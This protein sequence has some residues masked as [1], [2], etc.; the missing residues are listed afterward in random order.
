MREVPIET[1]LKIPVHSLEQVRTALGRAGA[2]RAHGAIREDNYLLDD[3]AGRMRT[4][5]RVLRVRLIGDRGVLTLKGPATYDGGVKRRRE[6]EVEI[7]DSDRLLEILARLGFETVGR[8]Q[9]VRETWLLGGAEVVLDRTPI[10][11]FVEI[12]GPP[13]HLE[14]AARSLDLDPDDAVT[15]SYPDLWLQ[16]RASHPDVDLP[17]DMVFDE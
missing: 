2:R 1:E 4:S 9:K 3:D 5:G 7:A 12:E 8:Y 16:Y 11:D 15:E 6:D 17:A 14:A 13:E 10:G